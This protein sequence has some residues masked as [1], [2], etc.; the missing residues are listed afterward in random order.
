MEYLDRRYRKSFYGEN[1][2]YFNGVKWKSI[3]DYRKGEKVLT[4]FLED[5]HVEMIEPLKFIKEKNKMDLTILKASYYKL[6]MTAE[7]VLIGKTRDNVSTTYE[8]KEQFGNRR[9]F[10]SLEN[11]MSSNFSMFMHFIPYCTFN[12]NSNSCSMLTLDELRVMIISLMYGEIIDDSE[13]IFEINSSKIK[14]RLLECLRECGIQK[15]TLNNGYKYKLPRYKQLFLDT[16][17]KLSKEEIFV[18]IDEIEYMAEHKD[19][20]FPKEKDVY[21]FIQL[22]YALG[23]E[24]VVIYDDY[25]IR[26]NKNSIIHSGNV[27]TDISKEKN[28]YSFTTVTGMFMVRANGAIIAVTDYKS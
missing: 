27:S 7:T 11:L 2:E 28:K 26:K 18:M 21:D 25:I 22:L 4:Y 14:E 5:N 10:W 13:C 6:S 17:L 20:L 9:S 1:V 16:V 15:E 12:Y 24:K 23:G 8:E 19:R 3:K